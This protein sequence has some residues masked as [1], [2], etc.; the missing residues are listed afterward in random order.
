MLH[1]HSVYKL[2]SVACII[3]SLAA[4]NVLAQ[5]GTE[6]GAS[7]LVLEEITVYS[8]KR[9]E[10][11]QDVPIAITAFGLDEIQAAGIRNAVDVAA[12]T[13]GFNMATLFSGDGSTPVIRGL[14]TTIGEPNVG[15]FVDGVYMGS[16]Q[17]MTT[18]LGNFVQSIEVA[19]GPQSA[20]YGR[21]TFGGAIN[22]VTRQPGGEFEGEAEVQFGSDG[23]QVAR[24]MFGG[25]FGDSNF[26]YR[27]GGM[28]DTFDGYYR[29]ELT[30]GN[31][32][33]RETK[34]FLG[35]I[36]WQSD[37]VDVA[38]NVVIDQTDNGDSP[39]QYVENN[40]IPF[41][42]FGLPSDFQSFGGQLP[43][44][45]SGYAVTPGGF[46]RDQVFS[47]LNVNWDL[48][49][50][51]L[52]SITGYNEFEH[53]R[54][55]DDDYQAFEYHFATNDTSVTEISQELRLTSN[56]EGPLRWMAGIYGYSREATVDIDSRYL[57]FLF[58]IFGGLGNVTEQ[59]TDDIAVFGSVGF[60]ITEALAVTVSGRYGKED[61]SVLATDTDLQTG[62][63]ATF[64]DEGSWSA[65]LPR[66]ALDWRI[67][68]DHM[69]YFSYSLSEKS[70][71]FNIVTAAGTILP[72]ERTYDPEKSDN[73]EI[74][75]KSSF[76]DRKVAT[77]IAVYYINWTDQIVRA[78]GATNA[79]LN[80]NAGETTSKGIEAELISRPT[81]RLNIRLGISYNDSQYDE[82]IFGALA[83]LGGNPDLSGNTLQYT[84]EWT[85]NVSVAYTQPVG[86]SDWEWF[87]R[88]DFDYL[89]E[90]TAVQ[91][92]SAFVGS[93]SRLNVN[94]G[95][96]ND[97]W[98]VTLWAYNILE[99][100]TASS[101][102]FLPNPAVLPDLFV[103]GA[104]SGFQVFQALVTGPKLR[105]YGLTLRYDF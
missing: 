86:T 15:F 84:P 105:S 72:Q 49:A 65:F 83:A 7:E 23:K 26:S 18:I 41:P 36:L 85:A 39:L 47:S 80:V 13:P 2:A 66:L 31:L 27:V 1:L 68:D 22:Y 9:A 42:A 12:L 91:T 104:R 29:N 51:T 71:G 78:L 21:N 45:T 14:S 88:F 34:G 98:R 96:G 87:S 76:A 99:N 62:V 81:D 33:E 11:L 93:S 70:G 19:K 79:V 46:E 75:L 44:I 54:S 3:A 59:D 17:T 90:Q 73:F 97:N 64:A 10:A 43:D 100:D 53:N 35:S 32:D 25:S 16:R 61:K 67:N 94:T 74:G 77:N 38:L 50:A 58:G 48:G 52:T 101:G 57:G 5:A 4:T 63:S 92:A 82:Y 30:G 24:A 37:N 69:A 55:G 89:D 20:L 56:A 95:F 103:F 8:R 60:D 102:V 6:A 28:Y 40:E